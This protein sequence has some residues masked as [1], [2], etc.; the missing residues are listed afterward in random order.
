MEVPDELFK[1]LVAEALNLIPPEF[2]EHLENVEV[3]IE[4]EARAEVARE[5]RLRLGHVLFGLYSGLPLTERTHDPAP[6]PDRITLFRRPLL[7]HCEDLGEL[8]YQVI[9]T[10]LHE[11]AHHF[12]IGEQRLADLGWG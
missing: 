7:D 1:E 4:D 8:R 10:V 3:V 11:V 2:R 6:F 12:G 5:L 9:T